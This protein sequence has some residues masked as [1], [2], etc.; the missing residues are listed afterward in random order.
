[1]AWL[2]TDD[3]PG[4]APY[5][6]KWRTIDGRER[7]RS[8]TDKTAAKRFLREVETDLDAGTYVDTN[9]GKI[10]LRE[11]I[12]EARES[13]IDIRPTTRARLDSAIDAQILPRLGDVPIGRIDRDVVQAWVND[14]TK[15]G[16]APA[17]V[18]K[19]VQTLSRVLR[20]AVGKRIRSNPC[21]DPGL[22]LPRL[23]KHE[24]RFLDVDEVRALADA[25]GPTWDALVWIGATCGLRIGEILALRWRDVDLLHGAITVRRTASEANGAQYVGPTKTGN[26]RRAVP[27]PRV[28]VAAVRAHMERTAGARSTAVDLVFPTRNGTPWRATNFRNRVWRPA[29]TAADLDGL[30]PHELRHTAVSLWIAHGATPNEVAAWAGHGTTSVVLDVYGHL[31]PTE[32]ARVT[33]RLD[34]AFDDDEGDEAAVAS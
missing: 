29:C 22:V 4:R 18:R 16:L 9:G 15:S 10:V 21:T 2:A 34:A 7:S 20:R 19:A 1:M 30:V 12:D 26:G 32:A 31:F 8:F 6:V 24:A 5:R 3:R 23:E 25:I 17:T 27:M 28:A 33:D 13:W 14:L 11:W